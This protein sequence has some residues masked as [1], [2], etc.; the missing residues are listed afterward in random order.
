MTAH[1][2]NPLVHPG[3][4]NVISSA[5]EVDQKC[6]ITHL[7]HDGFMKDDQDLLVHEAR[8]LWEAKHQ[9]RTTKQPY[10]RQGVYTMML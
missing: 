7:W 3:L 5:Q 9:L 8:Q 4:T 2:I 1:I 10:K 6:G